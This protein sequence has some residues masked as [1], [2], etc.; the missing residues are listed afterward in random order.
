MVISSVERTPR[1]QVHGTG[2]VMALIFVMAVCLVSS[3]CVVLHSVAYVCTCS[4]NS[5]RASSAPS[6]SLD[7]RTD[8]SSDEHTSSCLQ[9]Y[10]HKSAAGANTMT[11]NL[12]VGK[13]YEHE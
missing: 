3:Q 5:A 11:S 7:A 13:S 9:T 1:Q 2:A 8:V 12:G 4:S 10:A 6:R